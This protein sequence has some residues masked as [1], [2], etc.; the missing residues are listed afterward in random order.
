M[1]ARA[2]SME[3]WEPVWIWR[4]RNFSVSRFR[5]DLYGGPCRTCNQH[6]IAHIPGW[7]TVN[8]EALHALCTFLIN[9]S[10]SW[11]PCDMGCWQICAKEQGTVGNN[12]LQSCHEACCG[13]R[14]ACL[15]VRVQEAGVNDA[16]V[17]ELQRAQVVVQR[18]AHQQ[19]LCR[20]QVQDAAA[21][22][23]EAR[24]D[25]RQHLGGDARVLR[26]VVR[27]GVPRQHQLIQQHLHACGSP[28]CA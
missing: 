19:A 18:M 22:V 25:W 8:C 16:C 5:D 12:E 13:L 7:N 3:S 2:S 28:F 23:L 4:F 1:A 17:H 14:G 26:V 20:D 21:D 11:W 6:Q 27:D 9:C 15:G 10:G 24:R